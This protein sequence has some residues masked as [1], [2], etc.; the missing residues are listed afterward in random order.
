M[1]SSSK[2]ESK[3]GFKKLVI[4]IIVGIGLLL[5]MRLMA[6]PEEIVGKL[7][8]WYGQYGY[9]VI[10]ISA[11]VEGTFVVNLYFP[12]STAIV[13][14]V[15]LASQNELSGTV[16]IF[17][18]ILGF[19]ISYNLNYFLGKYGLYRLLLRFGYK[20]II[21]GT[22]ESLLAKGPRMMLASFFHP[23]VGSVVTTGAGIINMPLRQFV[24]WCL[25]SL[26]IWDTVWGVVVYVLG[27]Q[28]INLLSS[29]MAI[30]FMLLWI[31]LIYF[32]LNRNKP[33]T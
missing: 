33:R 32:I 28:V 18:T 21:E 3:S 10:F 24:I 6:T 1:S 15:A 8:G 22:R 19:F 31:L 23:N 5:V 2:V 14:G 29:W 12:G 26:L 11:L 30:P 4:S 13:L 20:D 27:S 16:L 17:L 9:W 25:I 7:A